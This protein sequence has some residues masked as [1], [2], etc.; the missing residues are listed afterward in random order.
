MR[1]VW[2][3]SPF[4][5]VVG[6]LA[7][8]P[9]P[10]PLWAEGQTDDAGID[11]RADVTGDTDTGRVVTIPDTPCYFPDPPDKTT[12]KACSS[13]TDCDVTGKGLG[14]CTNKLYIL[15]PLNPTDVCVQIDLGGGDACDAGDGTT[16]PLCDGDAGICVKD[17]TNPSVCKGVCSVDHAGTFTRHCV[18]KNACH[19]EAL[20]V[21]SSG[22]TTLF[23][24]CESGCADDS[25]CPS[26]SVCDPI[27]GFCSSKTCTSDTECSKLFTKPPAGFKCVADDT[28]TQ[29]H[30]RWAFAKKDGDLCTPATAVEAAKDCLCFGRT[31]GATDSGVCT[32][33]CKTVAFGAENPECAVGFVCDSL[34][35]AKNKD[36]K[37]I[38]DPDFKLPAGMAGFCM[39]ACTADA[40]CGAA[41]WTCTQSAGTPSKTCHPPV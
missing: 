20:A 11:A 25:E 40:D 8:C 41:G 7:G 15:T 9:D 37:D 1:K 17:G 35:N 10:Q 3:A 27:R 31:G 13:D 4:V 38:Y 26:G 21:D 19:P 30:C 33:N 28:G 29:S 36:G 12:G 16:V 39:R 14:H 6:G 18:G 22:T 32:S 23:G 24:S 34:L 2:L 5:V